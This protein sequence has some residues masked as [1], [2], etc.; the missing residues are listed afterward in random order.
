[1]KV[2]CKFTVLQLHQFSHELVLREVVVSEV[3]LQLTNDLEL[4]IRRRLVDVQLNRPVFIDRHYRLIAG[5]VRR[6]RIHL[7]RFEGEVELV[8]GGSRLC[9]VVSDRRR[10][11]FADCR[12]PAAVFA[13]GRV[14]S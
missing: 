14:R 1:M 7:D 6:N 10:R 2:G 11:L 9:F 3:V 5:V 12:I 8:D 13:D 4:E